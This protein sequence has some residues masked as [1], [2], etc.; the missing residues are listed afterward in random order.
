VSKALQTKRY[1]AMDLDYFKILV[2]VVL[3][4][5]GWLIAHYFTSKRD[6]TT[7]R[8]EISINHLVKAYRVL[9][10]EISHRKPNENS[11]LVLENILSDIQL[12]GSLEQVELAKKLADDVDA[13]DS[14]ELDPLI[15]SLRNEL[16]KPN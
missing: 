6:V 10:N 3:A 8:R 16:R 13:G 12:F 11:I 2:T 7:K 4:V 14:F 15:N 5:I 9:T 1:R